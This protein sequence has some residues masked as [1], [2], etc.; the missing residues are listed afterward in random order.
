MAKKQVTI[1]VEDAQL[2]AVEKLRH[3]TVERTGLNIPR[4]E[5][6]RL[7]IERG[8]GVLEAESRSRPR[9]STR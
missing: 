9:A 7:A 5:I 3:E 1:A 4:A 8:I 6:L 2:G